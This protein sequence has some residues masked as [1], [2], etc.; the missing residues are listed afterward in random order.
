MNS[1]GNKAP[2]KPATTPKASRVSD[3]VKKAVIASGG[4]QYL[5]KVGD[6]VELELISGKSAINFEQPLMTISNGDVKVGKP[7]VDG[8]KVSAEIISPSKMSDKVISITYKAKKRV[9]KIQG[10]RQKFTEVKITKI[11]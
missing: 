6:T 7:H 1:V 9:N 11:S 2:A 10:H 3:G 4:K 5:V 8:A